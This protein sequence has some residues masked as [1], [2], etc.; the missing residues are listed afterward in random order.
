MCCLG[1]RLGEPAMEGVQL[2]EADIG[3]YRTVSPGFV[4][5]P[6]ETDLIGFSAGT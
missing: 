2:A 6:L 4:L 5:T 3:V 1:S